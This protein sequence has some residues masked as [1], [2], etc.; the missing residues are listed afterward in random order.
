MKRDDKVRSKEHSSND[1]QTELKECRQSKEKIQSQYFHCKKELRIKTEEVERLKIELKD[2]KEI[3]KLKDDL[4]A[5]GL[6]ES[7][8]STGAERFFSSEKY[9]WKQ[10]S[11]RNHQN[12]K[13][14]MKC[15]ECDYQTETT[16]GIKK[17]FDMKHS[18]TTGEVQF[19][20]VECD[21]QGTT[22][23]QLNKHIGLKHR[24]NPN[25]SGGGI[26]CNNCG[27]TFYNKR[28]LLI[29]RK[30]MHS[31]TVAPCRNNLVGN[32]DF[33][34]ESCWWNHQQTE[35][36]PENSIKCYLCN[37]IFENKPTMMMHRKSKHPNSVRI[38]NRFLQNNCGFKTCWYLH[39]EA[40]ETDDV[41]QE[42]SNV[43]VESNRMDDVQNTESVFQKAHL[44]RKPPNMQNKQK[45][46]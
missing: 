9:S 1:I 44:N 36:G 35:R 3:L 31:S 19:N 28:E 34:D 32:C 13:E 25:Q 22:L 21:F 12:V 24:L 42:E 18:N 40:M 37:E 16:A 39:E 46:D 26:K 8:S 11:Q 27:E 6:R 23:Q 7:D 41:V 45:T 38:C 29:H 43:E 33:S 10:K 4:E 5:N 15:N 20:C 2:L 30:Q 17:H 14:K